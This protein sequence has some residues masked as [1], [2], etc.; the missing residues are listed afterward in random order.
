MREEAE[1][2]FRTLRAGKMSTALEL[3]EREQDYSHELY[4]WG[5]PREYHPSL[6]APAVQ[7]VEYRADADWESHDTAN[8]DNP[9]VFPPFA[10]S[11]PEEQPISYE[12]S[13]TMSGFFLKAME[14]Q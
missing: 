14:V 10:D 6:N 13:K 12:K 2:L 7:S 11:E 9:R 5:T 1:A 3:D 8:S 4:D